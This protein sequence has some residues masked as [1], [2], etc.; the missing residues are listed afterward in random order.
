M[1]LRV[2]SEAHSYGVSYAED[3]LF[4]TVK[5][6]IESGDWCAFEQDVE[7]AG[8]VPVVTD[9]PIL[10]DDGSQICGEGIIM[11]DGTKLN[12]GK[13]FDYKDVF[14]GFY[15]DADVVSTDINGNFGVHTNADDY[16]KYYWDKFKV[17]DEEMLISMAT[18]SYTH[19]T[20]PTICSL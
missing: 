19:L 6:R 17:K 7:V 5:V 15:M 3:I 14:L 18:V 11:P 10:D 4:V 20:L 16:M 13:G 9:V 1:G 8:N 2:M 12:R